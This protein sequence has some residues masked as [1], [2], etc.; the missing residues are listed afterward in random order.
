MYKV[1]MYLKVRQACLAEGISQ[2]SA[3]K[4]FG[5]SRKTVKKMLEHSVPPGYQRQHPPSKPRLEEH[6]AFIDEI[7]E[8]DT[9]IHRKQRHTMIRIFHRLRDE[10]GYSGSY[11]TVRTYV[12]ER[13][14]QSKE[15]FVPLFHPPG[16]AQVDFGEAQAI[17]GGVQQ[18][19]HFYVMDLPSSDDCFVKAYPRETTE[20]FLDGHVEA[21]NYFGGV[22]R[23]ILYDNLKIAVA[24]ILGDGKRKKSRAFTEL[25]SHYLFKERFARVGKGNDKGKVENLVGY[26]RRNFMVPLPRFESLEA[27]NDHLKACCL[28]RRSRILR[29]HQES[30]GQRLIK[31]SQAFLDLPNVPYEPCVV[32]SALVSSQSLVRFQNNDYSV[33]VAYGYKSVFVKAYV[34]RVVITHGETE[35]ACHT[36]SYHKGDAIFEPRHYLPLLERKTGAVDQAAPFQNWSLP[37][38]F[39]HLKKTLEHREGKTG[40]REYIKILR[41]LETYSLKEVTQALQEGLKMGV[42]S[43]DGIKHLILCQ[44][45][46]R[47]PSLNLLDFP[48]IPSVNVKTTQTTQYDSLTGGGL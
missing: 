11:T 12:A 16:D 8:S 26:A 46:D 23:S 45:E 13:R 1:E 21:F 39:D 42:F 15:M 25:Q 3:S 14:K 17:I 32:S 6:K 28:K 41:L 9:K 29:G 2:R 38:V 20:A 36:R 22:P 48:H 47:P 43:Q 18:K 33:P 35:I 4:M 10:R 34:D 27:L 5:I 19:I 24:R 40:T 37:P 7:L 44:M 30:I 31:D